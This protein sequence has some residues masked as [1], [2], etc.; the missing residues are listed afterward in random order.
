LGNILE[1]FSKCRVDVNYEG[2]IIAHRL[3]HPLISLSFERLDD[4]A[5]KI[6]IESVE[7]GSRVFHSY[8]INSSRRDYWIPYLNWD[9]KKHDRL[10]WGKP[11]IEGLPYLR[12][13]LKHLMSADK[14][15]GVVN[16]L[17][18]N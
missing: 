14:E 4:V 5:N 18:G 3:F 10:R 7:F 2:L 6:S 17:I 13:S 12:D 9:K 16:N 1:K 8:V 15:L 11:L